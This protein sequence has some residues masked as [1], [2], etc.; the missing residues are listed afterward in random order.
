MARLLLDWKE[1]HSNGNG[2]TVLKLTLTHEEMAQMIGSSRETVTRMLARFRAK[3][4][5]EVRG[6]TL[7]IR[8]RAALQ[9]LA[10]QGGEE[11]AQ[12]AA[13]RPRVSN[14]SVIKRVFGPGQGSASA[15]GRS[16]KTQ[17]PALQ[18]SAR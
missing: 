16:G 4:Y 13:A 1:T 15:R 8:N 11:R 2:T 14:V 17:V 12:E 6:S 9:S 5:I 10:D 18:L 7:V 3:N